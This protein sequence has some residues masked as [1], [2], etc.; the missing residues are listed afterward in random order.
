M[1]NAYLFLTA[2]FFFSVASSGQNSLKEMKSTTEIKQKLDFVIFEAF[3]DSLRSL[4]TAFKDE[5]RYDAS[6]RQTQTVSWDCVKEVCEPNYMDEFTY[7]SN[8]NKS[9]YSYYHRDSA[10]GNWIL[11]YK[12]EMFYDAANNLLRA[13]ESYMDDSTKVWRYTGK[14]D[15]TYD[16]DKNLLTSTD[17]KWDVD[18]NIWVNNNK[19]QYEYDHGKMVRDTHTIWNDSTGIWVNSNKVDYSY[20]S[21]GHETLEVEYQWNVMTSQWG[22]SNKYEYTYNS[23]GKVTKEIA[24][25]WNSDQGIWISSWQDEYIWDEFGNLAMDYEYFEIDSTG[26]WLTQFKMVYSY[27]NT[28]N[29]ADL[30]LPEDFFPIDFFNHKLLILSGLSLVDSTKQWLEEE[31]ITFQYSEINIGGIPEISLAD[32]RVFPNPAT[33]NIMI[34]SDMPMVSA[35]FELSDIQGRRILSEDLTGTRKTISVG[36]LPSGVYFY[37]ISKQGKVNRGKIMIR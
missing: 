11:Y 5:Y 23:N 27:D 12:E 20:D 32:I 17:F 35:K 28:V 1:K 19:N 18:N 7:D 9:L 16:A 25:I 6:G 29:H 21:A 4:V 24:Y 3:D 10:S 26:Q 14:F 31:R 13:I 22:N 15:R 36:N 30:I 34:E 33:D 37:Q 8:G 2:F